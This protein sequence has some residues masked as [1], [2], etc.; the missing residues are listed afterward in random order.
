MAKILLLPKVIFSNVSD[1]PQGGNI[2]ITASVVDSQ[3][4]PLTTNTIPIHIT[5]S[6]SGTGSATFSDGS[7]D[8]QITAGGTL[9][10]NGVTA[11]GASNN[12]SVGAVVHAADTSGVYTTDQTVATTSTLT[13]VS[14]TLSLQITGTVPTDNSAALQFLYSTASSTLGSITYY[15]TSNGTTRYAC[16]EAYQITGTVSPSDYAGQISLRRNVTYVAFNGDGTNQFASSSGD[17]TSNPALLD[18]LPQSGGSAG[19]VYDLDAP[20]ANVDVADSTGTIV[21][22]RSNFQEYAVIGSNTS[23]AVVSQSN[24]AFYARESCV[25]PANGIPTFSNSI[26]G[27]NQVGSG[28]T[29]LT[30][31]LN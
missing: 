20:A 29:P 13:V 4:N 19:K 17:D 23:T 5:L 12:I 6:V 9:Q 18:S 31:D 8:K 22:L 28:S 16:A 24:L 21:R 14:V 3:G 26:S 15:F 11:S 30:W 27:D 2:T 10:I 1:V 25:M 7:T